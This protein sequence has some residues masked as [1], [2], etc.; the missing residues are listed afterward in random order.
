[1]FPASIDVSAYFMFKSYPYVQQY[2]VWN[3][4]VGEF[5]ATDHLDTFPK[6]SKDKNLN[7]LLWENWDSWLRI[8]SK[9]YNK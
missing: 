6:N 8:F 3:N 2:S 5:A 7:K 4:S 9:V 1:M